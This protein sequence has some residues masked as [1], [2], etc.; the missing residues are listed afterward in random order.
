MTSRKDEKRQSRWTIPT[1][2]ALTGIAAA[3]GAGA[4]LGVRRMR[5]QLQPTIEKLPTTLATIKAAGEKA[6][7]ASTAVKQSVDRIGSLAESVQNSA[8]KTWLRRRLGFDTTPRGMTFLERLEKLNGRL[9]EFARG[10]QY[11]AYATRG[12]WL[13]PNIFIHGTAASIAA[14]TVAT[15]KRTNELIDLARNR[16]AGKAPYTGWTRDTLARDWRMHRDRRGLRG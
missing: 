8:G 15:T 1:S 7:T 5:R 14:S 3:G 12:R 2:V 13:D 10:D 11:I 4:Y 9:T 6:A 16:K